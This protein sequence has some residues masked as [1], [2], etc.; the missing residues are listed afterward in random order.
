[1]KDDRRHINLEL[2]SEEGKYLVVNTLC[3]T[4]PT[5]RIGTIYVLILWTHS[6]DYSYIL[7]PNND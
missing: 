1:M 3:H 5:I 2:E 6:E 7:A 4:K